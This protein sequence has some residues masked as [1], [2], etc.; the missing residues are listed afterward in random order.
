MAGGPIFPYTAFPVTAGKVYPNIHA[1][2]T[3]VRYREGLGIMAS[4]DGDAIW[5]L[6]FMMPQ[7]LPSGT[8]KLVLRGIA[9]ASSGA[10]KLNPRWKS[11]AVGESHALAAGSY[12]V[13]G[14]TTI[15]F[16]AVDTDHE[17][18]IVL[19]ADSLSAGKET[20]MLLTAETSGWTLAAV[21]TW[22]ACII[23][24]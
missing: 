11:V 10:A 24:E 21:S 13:E 6:R 17:A 9:N 3:N 15:T 18:K 5:E 4:L 16:S 12:S 2:Q 20:C 23:W 8:G 1:T 14:T 19:D 7:N 22:V